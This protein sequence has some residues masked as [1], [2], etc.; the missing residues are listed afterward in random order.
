MVEHFCVKFDDPIAA[1]VFE[2]SYGYGKTN[3]Q[4]NKR[5]V[6]TLPRQSYLSCEFLIKPYVL[7][8]M[9]GIPD[10]LK[11]LFNIFALFCQFIA[12]NAARYDGLLCDRV[13]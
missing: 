13:A 10:F 11:T 5:H 1:F 12:I 9:Y 7:W 4:T 8:C 3:R 2:I 6:K